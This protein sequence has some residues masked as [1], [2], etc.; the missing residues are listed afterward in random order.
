MNYLRVTDTWMESD[1]FRRSSNDLQ[2]FGDCCRELR[3]LQARM[4]ETIC[5][6][7]D[8]AKAHLLFSLSNKIKCGNLVST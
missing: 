7:P 8:A 6:L 1:T 3:F 2:F 5:M 4:R